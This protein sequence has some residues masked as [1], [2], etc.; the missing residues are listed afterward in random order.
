[1]HVTAS[2]LCQVHRWLII[3]PGQ[4]VL[5]SCEHVTLTPVLAVILLSGP[6]DTVVANVDAMARQSAYEL[7][8]DP[9]VE[10]KKCLS[11]RLVSNNNK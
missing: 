8:A 4:L 5:V 2:F 11:H 6:F 1:M 9:V 3:C 7:F 10:R